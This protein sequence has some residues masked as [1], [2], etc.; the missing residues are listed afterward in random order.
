MAFTNPFLWK[1]K[2]DV[3]EV[4]AK[5]GWA[6]LIGL[7]TSCANI[8]A[9]SISGQQCGSCSQCVERRIAISAHGLEAREP[10]GYGR[11]LFV[12]AHDDVRD[13][14]MIEAHVLRARELGSASEFS[15]LSRHGHVFR[16]VTDVDGEPSD[17][18]R[19]IYQ[20]H[21]R[22]GTEFMKVVDRELARHSS[23]DAILNLP[24][25]SLAAMIRTK[26]VHLPGRTDPAETEPSASMAAAADTR[27]IRRHRLVYACSAKLRQ[28]A[29]VDGPVL[30]G[31]AFKVLMVLIRQVHQDIE[32]GFDPRGRRY[33]P[34]DRMSEELGV[35][36]ENLR[37]RVLRIRRTLRE[38]FEDS[39]GYTLDTEDVIQSI[40]WT[41]YRL[42]PYLIQAQDWQFTRKP[43]VSRSAAGNVTSPV[44]DA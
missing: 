32:D 6:D 3:V 17:V 37:Q 2:S 24:D 23:L 42:S 36:Q 19:S 44:P 11:D 27:P 28:I 35:T 30:S 16:A 40:N 10:E 1:T 26:A 39:T 18:V 8:R 15:F 14:T 22:Y 25:N 7:T 38:A 34:S 4:I 12:G 20:L 41:G 31:V 13:L 21:K 5:N 9:Y 43:P 29:F 33:I